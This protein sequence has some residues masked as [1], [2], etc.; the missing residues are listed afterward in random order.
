VSLGFWPDEI[1]SLG[2]TGLFKDL[3]LILNLNMLVKF[4]F[5]F[6]SKLI[7]NLRVERFWGVLHLW[8]SDS[9]LLKGLLV[10]FDILAKHNDELV[11]DSN[12]LDLFLFKG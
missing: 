5:A 6:L 7:K 12:I 3:L 11:T 1:A 9:R 2:D 8:L 10:N 4:L